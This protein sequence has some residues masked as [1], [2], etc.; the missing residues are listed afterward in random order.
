MAQVPESVLKK[1]KRDQ[2]LLA[3]VAQSKKK[4]KEVRP[5][6]TAR[7]SVAC[8]GSCACLLGLAVKE[9]V[10]AGMEGGQ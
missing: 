6:K 7:K 9:G 8:S 10:N 2:E 3:T 1:Q 5:A 4:S